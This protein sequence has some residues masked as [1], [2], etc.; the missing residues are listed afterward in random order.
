LLKWKETIAIGRFLTDSLLS[1]HVQTECF[2]FALGISVLVNHCHLRFQVTAAS[3]KMT[4]FWDVV[5]CSLVEVDRR[6]RGAYTSY[7]SPR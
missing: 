6:F 3:L 2:Y 1:H 5:P 4:I 7:L